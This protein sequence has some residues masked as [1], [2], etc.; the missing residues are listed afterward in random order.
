MSKYDKC[1]IEYIFTRVVIHV[2][3]EGLGEA[4]G[5][6][7][8]DVH[9]EDD[10]VEVPLDVVHDLGLEVGL[11]VVG[12]DVEGHLGLNDALAD[13]LNTSSTRG[14]GGKVNQLVNLKE[15]PRN[16]SCY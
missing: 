14:R 15:V 8:A 11:P 12:G 1:C 2:L 5:S 4:L 7:L 13:V 10:E 3:L 16:I 6:E 9:G